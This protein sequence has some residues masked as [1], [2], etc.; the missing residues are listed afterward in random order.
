[1]PSFILLAHRGCSGLAEENTKDAF[2]LASQRADAVEFDVRLTADKKII[3]YHDKDLFRLCGGARQ[4]SETKYKD[5]PLTKKGAKILL[6]DEVLDICK[7]LI[8]HMEVKDPR[9][10][11]C[12][13]SN[14]PTEKFLLS[15]FD[16]AAVKQMS[17]KFP[18]LYLASHMHHVTNFGRSGANFFGVSLRLSEKIQKK[19]PSL[20][21]KTYVY[22]VNEGG[23]IISLQNN[24]FAGAYSD[25]IYKTPIEI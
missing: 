9:V 20:V 5:L 10:A 13:P 16:L 6:L 8:I 1:M 25:L 21:Q 18:T 2:V 12:L 22:T 24:G 23:K 11:F 7:G 3:V 19:H 15:S 14:L 17:K 4:I